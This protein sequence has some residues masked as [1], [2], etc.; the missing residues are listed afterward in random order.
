VSVGKIIAVPVRSVA[1]RW[2]ILRCNIR[3]VPGKQSSFSFPIIG[4][5]PFRGVRVEREHLTLCSAAIVTQIVNRA[6][7]PWPE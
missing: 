7:E 4:L 3:D 6:H 2:Q 1:F 5:Q